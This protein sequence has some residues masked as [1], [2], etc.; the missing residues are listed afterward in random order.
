[1][2]TACHT[3]SVA[4][5]APTQTPT[6]VELISGMVSQALASVRTSCPGR[7]ES[8]DPVTQTVTVSRQIH[9]AHYDATRER[10]TVPV[11]PIPDVPVFFKGG[12]GAWESH[13]IEVGS[14]GL[15][16]F[17]DASIEQWQHG[18]VGAIADPKDDRKHHVSD[19]V[20]IPGIRQAKGAIGDGGADPNAWVIHAQKLLLGSKHAS[21]PVVRQSDLQV[22]VNALNALTTLYNAHLHVISAAPAAPSGFVSVVTVS[23]GS[24]AGSATGSPKVSL[25]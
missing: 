21:D 22:V 23:L 11:P 7:V 16:V 25:E 9:D 2:Q 20:F 3:T 18:E 15:I 10:Q 8:Y 19:A 24:A 1:M 12:S 4:L 14:T 5:P 13:P 6:L 17:C